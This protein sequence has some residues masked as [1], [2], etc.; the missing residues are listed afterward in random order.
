MG[1]E[2]SEEDVQI[3]IA[4]TS[5]PRHQAIVLLKVSADASSKH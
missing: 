1:L 2:P 5:L 4:T 3:V